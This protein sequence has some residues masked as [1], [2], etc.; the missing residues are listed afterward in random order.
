MSVQFRI[1]GQPVAEDIQR[2]HLVGLC[3]KRIDDP[4]APQRR[5]ESP[6]LTYADN[7]ALRQMMPDLPNNSPFLRIYHRFAREI[8]A[9]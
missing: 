3:R 4:G 7:L 2:E 1:T 8:V 6:A 5:G 9:V